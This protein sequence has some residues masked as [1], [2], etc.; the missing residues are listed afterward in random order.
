MYGL[1]APS[2]RSL[3]ILPYE[4]PHPK[5]P[6]PPRPFVYRNPASP[7]ITGN[8]AHLSGNEGGGYPIAATQAGELRREEVRNL[9]ATE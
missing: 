9:M 4:T 2:S 5:L 7:A 1:G 3:P 8:L 6:D